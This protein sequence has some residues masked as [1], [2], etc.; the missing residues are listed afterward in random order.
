[1]SGLHDAA[2][3]RLQEL[4][5]LESGAELTR[6]TLEIEADG[7][8]ELVTVTM[9]PD[10]TLLVSATD[11]RDDGPHVRA[12]LSLLSG[13]VL[14]TSDRPGTE[15][16]RESLMPAPTSPSGSVSPVADALEEL[17]LAT[18][19]HGAR[20]ALGAPAVKLAIQ[21]LE[22]V[23]GKPQPRGVTRFIG[24]LYT[25]LA[26]QD[27][28]GLARVLDG[29][30]RV[31]S[32]LRR[33][34][35]L[36]SEEK[37]RIEAWLGH[38]RGRTTLNDQEFIE[39]G[40]EWVA[41]FNRGALQRRYLVC[42]HTGTMYREE[43]L[44]SEQGSVGPCPRKIVAGLA[45]HHPWSSP[46][47]MKL[48]QY[49]VTPTVDEADWERLVSMAV[50]DFDQLA[51][52]YRAALK[53]DPALAEP[54]ALVTVHDIDVDRMLVYDAHDAVLPL[55]DDPTRAPRR[56]GDAETADDKW[57]DHTGRLERIRQVALE[58]DGVRCI[59]GRLSDA[60]SVLWLEPFAVIATKD[61]ET[62]F[63]RL[64]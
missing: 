47:E 5:G 4:G 46:S 59:A 41:G 21:Q 40:R 13:T 14:R 62:R 51:P 7:R 3:T 49:A 37:R 28:D 36:P 60:G 45:E 11:G 15:T 42:L 10:G 16:A 56:E 64:R 1:M 55:R 27:P 22:T 8:I 44:R 25:V 52:A 2:R 6:A 26:A 48:L 38:E 63:E 35:E 23:L 18:V 9:R 61:G 34:G 58:S 29:A 54:V 19:R 24:R 43:R 50:A 12:A 31:V 17:M 32:A 30:T 57:A 33:S 20:K 39:I 53:G